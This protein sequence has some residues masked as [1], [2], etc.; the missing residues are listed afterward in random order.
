M[1]NSVV[2]M[3]LIPFL[4]TLFLCG[5]G[6]GVKA[7]DS[8]ESYACLK[9]GSDRPKTFNKRENIETVKTVVEEAPGFQRYKHFRRQRSRHSERPLGL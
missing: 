2:F 4:C 9:D 7:I 5:V 6:R 3:D 8:G 1:M